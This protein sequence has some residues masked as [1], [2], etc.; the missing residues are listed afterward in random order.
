MSNIELPPIS[1]INDSLPQNKVDTKTNILPHPAVLGIDRRKQSLSESGSLAPI[2]DI[3]DRNNS[4][5]SS[6]KDTQIQI[7]K[8]RKVLEFGNDVDVDNSSIFRD[9]QELGFP[10]K[11][12]GFVVYN[13][14]PTVNNVTHQLSIPYYPNVAEDNNKVYPLLPP[15]LTDYI[16]CTIDVRIPYFQTVNNQ[17]VKIRQL[18]GTDLYTD[19]SDVVAM[20]YHDGILLGKAPF[21]TKII[22]QHVVEMKERYNLELHDKSSEYIVKTPGNQKNPKS[23]I[24][25]ADGDAT[26]LIVTLL[27]LP[28]LTHYQGAFQNNYNSRT[29]NN[30]HNGA[31]I[32]IY[33]VKYVPLN[34]IYKDLRSKLPEELDVA[35]VVNEVDFFSQSVKV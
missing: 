32:S 3:L 13:Q 31:T 26:D 27:I 30:S 24:K 5:A 17:N 14:L 11:H 25:I 15:N 4:P 22:D 12:L 20:C 6:S 28:T 7:S 10:R 1:F 23:I 33:E 8:E 29:F 18:W 21:D 34:S 9:I 16:N 2:I 35:Q 19:D